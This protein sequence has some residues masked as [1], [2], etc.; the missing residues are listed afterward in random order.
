MVCSTCCR[1]N[2]NNNNKKRKRKRLK[3]EH[4]KKELEISY[5]VVTL[6]ELYK[7]LNTNPVT[8]AEILE[9]DG[10]NALSP[11][12][13]TPEC[14]KFSKCIF[15]GFSLLLWAGAILCLIAF[16]I[17]AT[18]EGPVDE[19]NF[20]TVIRGGQ[21]HVIA[22]SD[23]VVG[24]IVVLKGG[25]IV[26]ADV[27]IIEAQNFKVNNSSLTGESEPQ[28]RSPECTSD[29][30]LETRNI[31]FF[32]SCALE[33]TAKAVVIGSGDDTVIG[34]IAGLATTI[35]EIETPIAR[36]IRHFIH[37]ITIL[38][39]FLGIIVGNVP[40]GL[41]PTVTVCLTLAAK[42]MVSHNCLVKNLE[43]VETLGSTSTICSDKTGTLTQNR[44]TFSCNKESPAFKAF[45]KIAILCNISEFKHGQ[46]NVPIL[47]RDVLGDASE[48]A[49]LKCTE[50]AT[51]GKVMQI[52]QSNPKVCE[53]PFSSVTKYQVSIHELEKDNGYLLVMKGAPEAI[54]DS[55]STILIN[56]KDEPLNNQLKEDFNNAYVELGGRGERVLGL[57]DLQLPV[58]NFPRGFTFN[59]ETPNFPLTGLRFV[60][61][62]AMIDPPRPSVPSAV[63]LCRS[64]GIRVIMVTGDHPIT[65]KAIAKIVGIIS[66]GIAM[67]I[68]GTD[69]SIEA[70]D[71][72]LLD[73]NFA[74]I[75]IGVEEGRIIFDN[76]KKSIF[77]T[78]S[79][80]IPEITPFLLFVMLEIPLALGTVAILCIDLGTDI[81]PAMALAYEQPE[82]DIMK[83]KPRDRDKDKLVNKRLLS[84]AYCQIGIIEAAA[85]FTCYFLTFKKRQKLEFL[86]QTSFFATIVVLQ[87]F[88]VII[89]K[90]RRNTIF[91]QGMRWEWWLPGIPFGFLIIVYDELRRLCI[92][93]FPGGWVERETYY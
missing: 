1:S 23:V 19:D 24:D 67:G 26:P 54:L 61:L 34:R 76:L 83:R 15:G 33:G 78:L 90:T 93:K 56:G 92:R 81:L 65:A 58:K 84:M 74:S 82:S 43:C 47:Q 39:V 7:E 87:V 91:K 79:S 14:I 27:R 8:A 40:E 85:G 52:R 57:C 69:V 55:C 13:T 77:Y 66:E 86:C 62:I 75:V 32:S 3:L 6:D 89:C 37:L 36:E 5:H 53:I 20:A 70:A 31:A 30:P 64:A 35:K 51:G 38:A 18:S 44:M 73:D 22:V 59:A 45:I 50:L 60:G 72:L 9:R 17:E 11:P 2:N 68:A 4:L 41:L 21:R 63:E 28:V 10:P 42:R 16:T 48:A 80:N 71:M 49:I 25:D 88:D 46:D 29:N 12:K